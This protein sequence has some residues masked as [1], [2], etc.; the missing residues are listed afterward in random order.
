MSHFCLILSRRCR[1]TRQFLGF[2]DPNRHDA[3]PQQPLWLCKMLGKLAC[4]A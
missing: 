2:G 4:R 1:K 3:T